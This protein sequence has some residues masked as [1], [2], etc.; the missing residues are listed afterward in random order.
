MSNKSIHELF[1]SNLSGKSEAIIPQ[2]S[3]RKH[4]KNEKIHT[5]VEEEEEIEEFETTSK[6][7]FSEPSKNIFYENFQITNNQ[8][9]LKPKDEIK[10]N[11]IEFRK[12]DDIFQLNYK[13]KIKKKQ[14]EEEEEKEKKNEK[15][16]NEKKKK[17]KNIFKERTN[18]SIFDYFFSC[19]I[20]ILTYFG[21]IKEKKNEKFLEQQEDK[22]KLKRLKK[23]FEDA[24]QLGDEKRASIIGREMAKLSK[25]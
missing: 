6:T 5:Q 18:D 9:I 22:L 11:Q 8:N 20:F 15:I 3:K 12:D 16:K 17:I 10:M 25:Y 14:Q 4:L 7:L 13:K 23:E 2:I 19:F 24:V 1:Y 21:L